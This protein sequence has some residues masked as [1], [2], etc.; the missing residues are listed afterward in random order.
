[1]K[2]QYTLIYLILT[3]LFLNTHSYGQKQKYEI[4]LVDSI[5]I[6][7]L[8]QIQIT[9][10]S[11]TKDRFLAYGTSTKKCMEVDRD[12]NI[13]SEVDLTGEGP[14]HFG[15]GIT[16][17][18][19]FGNDIIINGPN[20]YFTY[21]ENWNY[22][23]RIV[24]TSGG[25][26]LPLGMISG[27]P[28]VFIQ[29][30]TPHIVKSLDHTYFNTRRL[31]KE[32][33]LSASLVEHISANDQELVIPYPKNSVYLSNDAFYPSTNAKI[34]FNRSKSRMYLSLP[35]VPKLYVFNVE[36]DFSLERTIDL[37]LKSWKKPRG[38]SFED[39]LKKG[40]D[41]YPLS[42]IYSYLNSTIYEIS[43]EGDISMITHDSGIEGK[44]HVNTYKEISEIAKRENKVYTTFYL[45]NDKI[46]EVET[47]F[48]KPVR[49]SETTFLAHHINENEEVDYS[50]FY[51]YELKKVN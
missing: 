38:I 41:R 47:R 16:E 29:N 32:Y 36:Q 14:G 30:D 8:E 6:E 22:K 24:Y 48:L 3:S 7:S 51:I 49:I 26:W 18:G 9:D 15:Q 37:N 31:P 17:L 5:L 50:K 4:V 19:Y 28:E 1:M 21:D 39:Q 20:V 35:L 45:R 46:L 40:P 23:E 34:C 11:P 42:Q 27:A 44:E 33:F 25:A 43:C 10:Y 12:G 2:F 13:L